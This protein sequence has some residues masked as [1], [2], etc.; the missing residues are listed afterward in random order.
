[1]ALVSPAGLTLSCCRSLVG[2]VASGWLKD[3][4]ISLIL[5]GNPNEMD[6]KHGEFSTSTIYQFRGFKIVYYP[7]F[8]CRVFV[9]PGKTNLCSWNPGSIERFL[10]INSTPKLD[11]AKN[12]PIIYCWISLCHKSP[13]VYDLKMWGRLLIDGPNFEIL[14]LREGSIAVSGSLKLVVGDI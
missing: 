9:H 8:F 1:M 14:S 13:E 2:D 6:E 10:H 12:S 11:R 5:F 4:V 3:D 7:N